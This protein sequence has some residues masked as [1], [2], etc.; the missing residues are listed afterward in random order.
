MYMYML[1]LDMC[2]YMYLSSRL[3]LRI[4]AEI[5]PHEFP[6]SFLCDDDGRGCQVTMH[7]PHIS[8]EEAEGFCQL[9]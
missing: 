3:V 5:K 1:H 8:M 9:K 6:G 2:M 4:T 7:H